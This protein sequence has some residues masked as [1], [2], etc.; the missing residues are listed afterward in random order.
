MGSSVGGGEFG[1]PAAQGE[2]GLEG[3]QAVGGEA[4][5]WAGFGGGLG[6]QARK[7]P[8]AGN[9]EREAEGRTARHANKTFVFSRIE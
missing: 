1:V 5:R 3:C 2:G 4:R 9:G 7:A 8:L 6:T